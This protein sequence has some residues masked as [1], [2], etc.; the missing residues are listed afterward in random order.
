MKN[1]LRQNG[2]LLLVIAL[3]L[4]VL[5]GIVSLVMGG[6][7]D[8]LS[9]IVNTVTSPVRGGIAAAADW[10]E[11]VYAYV[12]RYGELQDE[13]NDLRTQV[14]RLQEEV[15]QGEEAVRENEQLRELLEFQ[16]RRRELT[17]EP[18]KVTARSTSNW[19]STLTLSKG[20]TSDIQA[21]DCV[22]TQTGALV[23]VVSEVGVNWSTV[24]TI[25]NTD[26]EMGGI[27][28]RTYSA[29]VLEGD[30][31]LMN[32]GRLKLNYLPEEAQLVSGDEVLTSGRGEVFPAGLLVGKV[33]GVFTD[34]SG[35]TRYAV[36]EPAVA[37]DNLI[38]VFVIKDFEITE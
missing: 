14:G 15:R 26:T 4:S 34:P 29:G 5:I 30:F 1:F 32:Q 16:T 37:L 33:E 2:I 8:P 3:L 28:T 12:F 10:V 11:S 22:I 13:L 27:V 9:N 18:A 19:E 23:G 21:G 35:Q 24:S 25:I 31:S 36:V 17:T 6:S 38:E 20:T 7:A